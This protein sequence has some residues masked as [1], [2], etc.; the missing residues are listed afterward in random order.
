M[1]HSAA[2]AASWFF[3]D[4]FHNSLSASIIYFL[5]WIEA[6]NFWTERELEIARSFTTKFFAE[7]NYCRSKRRIELF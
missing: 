4:I 2:Q 7:C 5:K 1:L 3:T 6:K